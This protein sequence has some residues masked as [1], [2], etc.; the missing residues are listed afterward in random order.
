[1]KV[2]SLP[3]INISS[4]VKVGRKTFSRGC[5]LPLGASAPYDKVELRKFECLDGAVMRF[6]IVKMETLMNDLNGNIFNPYFK[7]HWVDNWLGI[8]CSLLGQ[9]PFE[10]LSRGFCYKN[11]PFPKVRNISNDEFDY[12]ILLGLLSEFNVSKPNYSHKPSFLN[13]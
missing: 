2:T 7:H 11:S 4:Q 1:M 10:Y 8:Y 5:A 6:P 13:T 12:K 3:N 9:P